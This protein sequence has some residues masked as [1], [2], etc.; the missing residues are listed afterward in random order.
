MRAVV[1]WNTHREQ[2]ML[3]APHHRLAD[4]RIFVPGYTVLA[5]AW[6]D[7]RMITFQ[8]RGS[9]NGAPVFIKTPK[10]RPPP[11]EDLLALQRDYDIGASFQSSGILSALAHLR[12]GDTEYLVLPDDGLRP[13]GEILLIERPGIALCLEFAVRLANILDGLHRAQIIHKNLNPYSAWFDLRSLETKISDFSFALRSGEPVP[14]PQSLTQPQGDPRYIAPEQTG[15]IPRGTDPRTDLY[16]LGALLYHVVTGKPPFDGTEV[17][18][19]LHAHLARLPLP[20]HALDH[21]IP[22][23]FSKM[24]MKLLAKVPEERYQTARGLEI[25]LR[26]CLTQWHAHGR[27]G[28][29]VPGAHDAAAAFR[30]PKKLYGRERHLA[31]IRAA[32]ERAGRGSTELVLVEGAPG[33]GK[34]QLVRAIEPE[35]RE[36]GAFITAKFD[37]FKQNEPYSFIAQAFRELTRQLLSGSEEQLQLWRRR[38]GDSLGKNGRMITDVVPEIELIIGSQPVVQT[39]PAAEKRNLFNRLFRRFIRV[40]ARADHL[41]TMFLDDLQWADPASLELLRTLVT[42]PQTGHS[43]PRDR[44]IPQYRGRWL[45]SRCPIA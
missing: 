21:K 7:A 12:H 11:A 29:I 4:L 41:M 9:E 37:Q 19:L 5:R 10:A 28:G 45:R 26:E 34:S 16:S 20:P 6:D 2:T 24:I 22:E 36:C 3:G 23:P 39:L 27:I 8:G 31:A 15:R 42:D 17:L 43:L 35:A 25:D 38:L 40:F 18:E 14:A 44:R 33:V 30:M 1:L 13:A 32:L